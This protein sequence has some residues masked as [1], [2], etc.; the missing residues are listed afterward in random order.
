MH[1][2]VIYDRVCRIGYIELAY[3]I[4]HP[5]SDPIH[6]EQRV[7]IPLTLRQLS[8]GLYAYGFGL[9]AGFILC[10]RARLSPTSTNPP[11][12]T[13]SHPTQCPMIRHLRDIMS[14]R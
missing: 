3:Y 10:C 8:V 7:C 11:G 5:W 9:C 1:T 2:I 14:Y 4:S 6:V 13:R 12:P